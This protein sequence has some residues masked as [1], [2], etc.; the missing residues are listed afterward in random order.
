[1]HITFIFRAVTQAERQTVLLFFSLPAAMKQG[2]TWQ[3]V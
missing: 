1:M 2:R 3:C